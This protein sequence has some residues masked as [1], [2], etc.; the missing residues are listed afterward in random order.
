MIIFANFLA[1]IAV[2]LDMVLQLMVWIL[3][4]R[5]LISWVNPDPFNPIVRFLTSVTDP[6]LVPLRRRI[7]L[8]A[9]AFDFS[10][11]VLLLF[12]VFLQYFLVG[13]LKDYV[14]QIRRSAGSAQLHLSPELGNLS[15]ENQPTIRFL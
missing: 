12:L 10:P 3:V 14:G 6:L 11:I 8:V 2:V 13:T 9:G 1:G 15:A 7:P 4:I 5:A